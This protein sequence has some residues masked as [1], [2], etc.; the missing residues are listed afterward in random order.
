MSNALGAVVSTTALLVLAVVAAGPSFGWFELSSQTLAALAAAKLVAGLG[1]VASLARQ[2]GVTGTRLAALLLGAGV[3]VAAGLM[4]PSTG[5]L[6]R[7][8]RRP[9]GSYARLHCPTVC[10][11]AS[12]WP[13]LLERCPR[14]GSFTP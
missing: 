3:V 4:G 1:L 14:S 13:P 2:F 7:S 10:P 9:A 8:C 12:R 6:G 5:L 11:P